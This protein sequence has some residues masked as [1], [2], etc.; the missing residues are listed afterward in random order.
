MKGCLLRFVL[1]AV[2]AAG[3]CSRPRPAPPAPAADAAQ[4]ELAR[5]QGAWRIEASWWNGTPE[6]EAARTV[7]ILF[8][9]DKCVTVDRDGNRL[10]ETVRVRPEQAPKGID[11]WGKDAGPP[12]PGI[13]ALEGDTLRWCS[14]GGANP[15]RPNVFAS[16]PGS[17]H[18]L[19][20]LR[21][22]RP[23]ETP[24]AQ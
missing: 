9:G 17:R 20:V 4:A 13:Y 18:S 22:V 21:R 7:T 2:F 15:T 11:R 10:E 19:L 14:A 6:P 8:Q 16:E 24:A 23:S 12:A 3:A 1:V 5:L